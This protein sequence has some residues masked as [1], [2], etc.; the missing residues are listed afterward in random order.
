M[1]GEK[2]GSE[3]RPAV[4]D[5][6]G[7]IIFRRKRTGPPNP[8]PNPNPNPNP[9]PDVPS[10]ETGTETINGPLKIKGGQTLKGIN[11]R[12][13]LKDSNGPTHKYMLNISGLKGFG[14][15][16]IMQDSLIETSVLSFDLKKSNDKF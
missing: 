12:S 16:E 7:N 4:L 11:F 13:Y 9:N 2:L 5:P 6:D 1:G 8:D 14:N 10:N 3:L 15:I